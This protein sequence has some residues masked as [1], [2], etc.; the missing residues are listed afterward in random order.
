MK[1]FPKKKTP[2]RR[3][4]GMLKQQQQ[5]QQ[6]QHLILPPP[7]NVNASSA[8]GVVLVSPCH[9]NTYYNQSCSSDFIKNVDLSN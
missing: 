4:K 7:I 8:H 1:D 3:I 6:Q 9:E 2:R 5:H